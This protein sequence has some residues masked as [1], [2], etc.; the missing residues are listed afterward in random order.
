LLR[1]HSEEVLLG[2]GTIL[3]PS[4]RGQ[5]KTRPERLVTLNAMR[6]SCPDKSIA[7][8][9]DGGLLVDLE[10][11]RLA[12]NLRT[13]DQVK[14][15][16]QTAHAFDAE[17]GHWLVSRSRWAAADR[18]V[19]EY[20]QQWHESHPQESGIKVNSYKSALI[21][22]YE[23]PLLIGVLT[24]RLACGEF[25]LTGGRIR[26]ADFS[27][28]LLEES[29]S[30]WQR[31]QGYLTQ[32]SKLIPLQSEISSHTGIAA[33]ELQ[34]IARAAT[35]DGR[36]FKVS[37]RRYAL[38]AQLLDLSDAVIALSNAN[39][40]ISVIALKEHWRAGRNLT[41]EILEYFDSIRFTQRRGDTRMV[42]DA[43][44]PARLFD[45]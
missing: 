5:G 39:E 30:Q 4:S 40:S 18:A 37:D 25:K 9:V 12:W 42:L 35:H 1:D 6:E 7:R 20:L 38:P 31:V 22:H 23:M 21:T 27:P 14:V 28:T 36:L 32:C 2:G 3:D 11:F 15:P 29:V 43:D 41:V 19:F 17:G 24:A 16:T 34:Q 44:L 8:L 13:K 45:G 10:R 26:L 33:R